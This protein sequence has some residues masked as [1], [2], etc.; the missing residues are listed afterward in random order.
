MTM[1]LLRAAPGSPGV[2]G[3]F[4]HLFG[5]ILDSF[6]L[7]GLLPPSTHPSVSSSS[8]SFIH[9]CKGYLAIFEGYYEILGRF[10]DRILF[11]DSYGALPALKDNHNKIPGEIG[12]TPT[13]LG[14]RTGR[15]RRGG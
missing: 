9:P 2:M 7:F 15:A 14:T 3:F 6:Y 1:E 13:E 5:Y 11:E 4:P 8:H 12:N 10:S